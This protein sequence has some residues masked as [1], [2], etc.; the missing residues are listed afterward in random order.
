MYFSSILLVLIYWKQKGKDHRVEILDKHIH[1][2]MANCKT[3]VL[4]QLT[5]FFELLVSEHIAVWLEH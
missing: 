3:K 1:T 2:N 5:E 4:H